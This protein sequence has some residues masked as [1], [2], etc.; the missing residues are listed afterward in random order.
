MRSAGRV[1][2][3][4]LRAYQPSWLASDAIAAL[5]VSLLLVPQGLAYAALAGLP[6]QMGLYASLL[7]LIAYALFGSSRVM[8]VGPVAIAS[9]MTGAALAPVAEPGSAEYI[10]AAIFLA[11]LSGVM[12]MVFGWMRLGQLA[13]FLSHPVI[14]GFI[15]GAALLIVLGQLSPLLGLS[16]HGDNALALVSAMYQAWPTL[17]PLTATIGLGSLLVLWGC[18]TYLAAGL[19][20]LGIAPSLAQLLAKLAPMMVVVLAI[21]LVLLM[22]WEDQLRVVGAF[23]AG[24]PELALPTWRWD[25]LDALWLPALMIGLVG[26]IESVSIAHAFAAREGLKINA[27]AE[28]RGLG[29]ANI[30]SGLS[31][32]FPV[33]GGF[34]R[35][36]VNAEAGAKTPLSGVMAAVLIA[37]ILVFFTQLF[38]ALPVSVLAAT[39]IVAAVG[40]VDGKTLRHT[41]E[42]DRAEAWALIG[43][44]AGVLLA[45]VEMGIGIGVGLSLATLIWRA[46]QP[47]IAILGRVPGTEHF[48]NIK[49]FNVEIDPHVLIMRIDERLFFGNA[50]LVEVAIEQAVAERQSCRDVVLVMSSVSSIDATAD[51]MLVRV[52]GLLDAQGIR[53]HLAE[54]KGPVLDRLEHADF[55]RVLTGSIHLST[56]QALE[57]IGRQAS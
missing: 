10:A 44:G 24:L 51:E 35:T 14:S 55:S 11:V 45:G 43:T 2:P 57:R 28:L 46:S 39:I 54:V 15:S 22:A 50:E 56:H 3:A 26:F 32:A 6:V 36:A 33:T 40:L 4:W 16:A 7:P 34:S 20:Q 19:Q 53:L 25:W 31:G 47:H 30:V 8:S 52:N 48:R 12:L 1:M 42:Y 41:W 5:V 17:D 13:Y 27:D 38:S 49:R 18:K 23:P 21:A 37:L 29:A 9:L